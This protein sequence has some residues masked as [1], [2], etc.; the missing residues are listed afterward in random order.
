M[1]LEPLPDRRGEYRTDTDQVVIDPDDGIDG[2]A[3]VVTHE[4]AHHLF[5]AC[6]AFADAD[7]TAAFYA[8]QGLPRDRHWFDYS[9]GWSETPAEHFA[10]A[11]AVV[12]ASSGEGGIAVTPEAVDIVTRWLAGA[13]IA[14]PASETQNPSA[15]AADPSVT[16]VE[17]DQEGVASSSLLVEPISTAEDATSEAP[18]DRDQPAP[19][20]AVTATDSPDAE[21][22]STLG[23]SLLALHWD[24]AAAQLLHWLE[25]TR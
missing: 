22:I 7:F 5:L 9:A 14:L 13:P 10:E 23:R 6:G 20:V 12:I 18:P 21:A 25:G 3:G 2:M 15:Y 16:A 17:S 8:A 24:K 1:V 4:L 19:A 11:V